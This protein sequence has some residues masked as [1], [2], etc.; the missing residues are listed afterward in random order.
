V[1]DM[2]NNNKNSGFQPTE[3]T[4]DETVAMISELER[5]AA[6]GGLVAGISH[7][8]ST[9]LGLV[10]TASSHLKDECGR[11]NS[12]YRENA[13]TKTDFEELLK[14]FS[15]LS[16]IIVT[17]I[18]RTAEL[19]QSFKQVSVDQASRQ[20]RLFNLRRYIHEIMM[21]LKPRLKR[22][23]HKIAI[24]C[25][26]SINLNSYPGAFAQIITNLIMNSLTHGFENIEQG[27]IEINAVYENSVL[28]LIYRDNGVGIP[29]ENLPKIFQ[30]FFTTKKDKGGSGLGMH[31]IYSLVT[32][33]LH[34]NFE[35]KSS[36][37]SGV[38]F[39]LRI[40]S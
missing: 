40:P 14:Q 1:E 33:T 31:I 36:S 30:P 5:M 22:V 2:K 27:L 10:V 17:N 28:T 34:G 23:K 16:D 13:L 18:S 25:P 38:E 8:V 4:A 20:M 7:E 19:I 9:P 15:E 3:T 11:Y 35:C 21:T 39:T 24:N 12:L 26:D 6:L 37:G 32:E 29:E